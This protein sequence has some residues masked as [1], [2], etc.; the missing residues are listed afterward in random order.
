MFSK[1]KSVGLL[2]LE[3]YMIDVELNITNGKFML[4]IVGLPDTAVN[5]AR[6]RIIAAINNSGLIMHLTSHFTFNLAPADVRKEGS[7]YDLPMAIAVLSATKQIIGNY[8]EAVFWHLRED[9]G[10]R[11]SYS[12]AFG[13]LENRAN[14]PLARAPEQAA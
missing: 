11:R 8:K 2:G 5:E 10:D 1:I 7:L 14:E 9:G 12:K 3:S 4:D 6:D 13:W